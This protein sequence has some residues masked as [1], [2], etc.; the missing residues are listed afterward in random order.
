MRIKVLCL[1]AV[2]AALTC[3]GFS[4][5]VSAEDSGHAK[6]KH[7][8]ITID[9]ITIHPMT[10][11]VS[12]DDVVVWANYSGREVQIKFRDT[13]A[14]AFS[15]PVRPKF[16]KTGD[17]HLLSRP[18]GSLEFAL[19]CKLKPGEYNYRVLG[20]SPGGD[21]ADYEQESPGDPKGKIIVK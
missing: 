11:K 7:R 8:V 1:S 6:A 13:A 17:G 4:G 5:S 15:C 19:P 9:S 16:Y 3:A 14:D 10:A 21:P 2:A 20:L 18:F 12:A